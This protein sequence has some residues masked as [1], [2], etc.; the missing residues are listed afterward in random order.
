MSFE[1]VLEKTMNYDGRQMI[2]GNL[3]ATSPLGMAV[4][5]GGRLYRIDIENGDV[6]ISAEAG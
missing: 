4:I 3:C 2:L 5:Y 6:R 1:E